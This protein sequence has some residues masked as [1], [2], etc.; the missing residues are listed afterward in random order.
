MLFRNKETKRCL[1]DAPVDSRGLCM[2]EF[3]VLD[4][5]D[6]K[7]SRWVPAPQVQAYVFSTRVAL[8]RRRW[9]LAADSCVN[10]TDR[11]V[12]SSE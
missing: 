3:D 6:V 5:L 12:L 9:M 7:P 4:V 10:E 11:L 8:M 1:F 2:D